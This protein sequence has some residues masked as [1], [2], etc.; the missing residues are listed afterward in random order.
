MVNTVKKFALFCL[1]TLITLSVSACGL[2]TS[3]SSNEELPVCSTEDIAFSITAIK[4]NTINGFEL[5]VYCENRT[6]SELFF[7]WENVSVN[8]YMIDPMW[9]T[10]VSAGKK[11]NSDIVFSTGEL[12][13]NG[14]SEVEIVEFRLLVMPGENHEYD[15][16]KAVEDTVYT[17]NVSYL[18]DNSNTENTKKQKMAEETISSADA[19]KEFPD[20]PVE[21]AGTNEIDSNEVLSENNE[22][23][24]LF[25]SDSVFNTIEKNVGMACVDDEYVTVTLEKFQEQRYQ[26]DNTVY[27]TMFMQLCVVNKTDKEIAYRI[28]SSS[29]ND[30]MVSIFAVSP[31]PK[32]GK[33]NRSDCLIGNGNLSIDSIEQ[34]K[35]V[36]LDLEV[37]DAETYETLESIKN[38]E[39]NIH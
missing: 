8:G 5:A 28:D 16:E 12:R 21:S 35:S 6:N 32:P 14:I 9:G 19:M 33:I 30:E 22:T 17:L 39:I 7:T 25:S 2:S 1:V 29:I 13:K 20:T 23:D 24:D 27:V 38:I 15:R 31:A 18:D 37:Y 26:F 11:S 34:I 3:N 36:V 4:A 10:T